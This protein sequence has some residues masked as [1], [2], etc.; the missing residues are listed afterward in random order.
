MKKGAGLLIILFLLSLVSSNMAG[1]PCATADKGNSISKSGK[2]S[3]VDVIWHVFVTYDNPVDPGADM[4]FRID[5]DDGF[6]ETLVADIVGDTVKVV[7]THT[8][9]SNDFKCNHSPTAKLVAGGTECNTTSQDQFVTVWDNDDTNG[10]F[11]DPD[12]DVYPI[13]FGN[14]AVAQ[15]ADNTLWNCVP[16]GER[17]DPNLDTRWIQFVYGTRGKT[18]TGTPVMVDDT[19]RTYPWAGPVIELPGPDSGSAEVSLPITVADDKPVGDEFEIRLNYWNT[20]NPYPTEDPVFAYS[21]IRIMDYPNATITTPKDTACQYNPNFILTAATGGGIWSGT[22]IDSTTGEFSPL[23]AGPGTY[24]IKYEITD[25]NGCSGA[26]SINLVVRDSPDGIITPV[27]P[28]CLNGPTVDLEASSTDG[29]WT[30]NGITD[31]RQ[32]IFDPSVAGLGTH[33]VI[34]NTDVDPFGCSGTD[35]SEVMVLEPPFAEFLTGDSTWCLAASNSTTLRIRVTGSDTTTYDLDYTLHGLP[36]TYSGA[37]ADTIELVVNNDTGTNEYI[38]LSITEHNGPTSC[39]TLLNDTVT[40]TVETNPVAVMSY[41]YDSPCSPVRVD[42]ESDTGYARYSWNFGSGVIETS[43]HQIQQTFTYDYLDGMTIVGT[44]T[45]LRDDS[46]YVFTLEVE[47]HAGCTGSV[48]D[49]ITVYPVPTANFFVH[50]D[51]QDYPDTTVFLTNL[52]SIGNWSYIWIYGD[53]TNDMVKDPGQHAYGT[54]GEFDIELKA[55]SAFCRDSITRKILIKPPP[56]VAAFEPDSSGCPPFEMSFTNYSKYADHYVWDFGD[57]F[58]STDPDPKHVFY[59]TGVHHV[60]M[61]AFG[62]EEGSDTTFRTVTV[63]TPPQTRFEVTPTKSY[64]LEQEFIFFSKSVNAFKHKWD[65]GDG[66]ESSEDTT[67]HAYNKAGT[68]TITLVTVSDQGC[69]DTLVKE[70]M[71]MVIAGEGSAKFPN[72]FVWRGDNGANGDWT[73]IPLEDDYYYNTIFHPAVV[74]VQEYKMVIY[75]R[76]GIKIFESNDLNIG[77]DGHMDTGEIAGEGVYFYRAWVKYVD[78]TEEELRG[79]ITFL[80]EQ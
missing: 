67:T 60:Q 75:T 11:V 43:S 9:I 39:E 44:D 59:D 40:M 72:A 36:A 62:I 73:Q 15:F 69:T 78:G 49:S 30:G 33:Q 61:V 28:V 48:T 79:D 53:G 2:C 66:N 38:L 13:C 21:V 16:P 5:W 65:F 42:F 14:S 71:I 23:L 54:F 31:D 10:G 19:V 51:V 50:P 80:H 57:G 64:N 77:W 17:D 35:T 70:N 8:Y 27:D 47:T 58:Y 34:F 55:F 26:D 18:M 12:P 25:A 6:S 24:K 74:N 3:P 22:G 45:I 76:W 7:A 37:G 63:F 29:T 1:Q 46:V 32:G 68:Y 20:C 56:P 4:K 41:N 52:T